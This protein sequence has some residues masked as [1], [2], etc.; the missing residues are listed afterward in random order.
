MTTKGEDMRRLSILLG[1]IAALTL[2]VPAAYAESPHFI[3]TPDCSKSSSGVLTCTGRAAG[4]GNGPTVAFLT[5]DS[6]VATWECVNKG[7]NV[8]PGQPTSENQVTGPAQEITPRNGQIRFS[9][10]LE[11]PAAPDPNDVC[12]NGNWRVRQT[13]LTY[14]NV[15]L[16]IQQPEGND[17]LTFN[18]GDIDP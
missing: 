2:A 3:G 6:V 1:I 15:V 5:A 14:Y 10:S 7:G 11:P 16:H 9:P 4:L 13:S 12:P 17:V 8:A 18:A